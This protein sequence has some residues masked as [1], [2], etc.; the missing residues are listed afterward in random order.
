MKSRRLTFYLLRE[1]VEEFD[2]ALDQEKASTSVN[3]AASSGVDGRFHYL[4]PKPLIPAWVGFVQPL[5][6]GPLESIRS[7]STSGLLLLRASG[8]IFALTFGYGRSLLD[9]SKIEYQFGLRVALNRIDPRQIR[10]L[11]TKTFEDLVVST[12]TQASKSAEL[13]T[14]GVDVSKDILRAVTGEPRDPE[15]AK[16]IAGS[17]SLVMSVNAA[18]SDLP[19]LCNDLLSAFA[20]D[21]YKAEF[22]WI[23]QLSLVR[24]GKHIAALNDLLVAQLQSGETGSTHLAMPET[25]DWEDIDAFKIGGTRGH[26]YEDLDLDEYLH[27]LGDERLALT[28]E[29]L[30][31]RPVSIRFGRSGNFDKRWNLFQC[32]VTEQRL[33]EKLHV[34]IEG[35]WFAISDSL[36]GEVDQFVSGLPESS[37]SLISALPGEVEAD[38]NARLAESEPEHLLKLDAR[39]KRPGGATSG[40][41]FCDVLSDNGDLVHVK[42]KSR[43]STL[44]H[45]FAQG[46]VS[47]TTF[48]SDGHYRSEIRRLIEDEVPVD[49]RDTW[50]NLVPAAD[51]T[52]SRS[53]YRVTYAVIANSDRD[54]RDWLPFFSKLNLMQ[55]GRQLLNMGFGV[56]LAR[57][58][59]AEAT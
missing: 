54:G 31:S 33:E 57:V 34:L 3:L 58:P 43:S 49:T 41:E 27:R 20:A 44:S 23:D 26:I 2:D 11:D 39:I 35:R 1:E 9:L 15:F 36:V 22:G 52:V 32:I 6:D 7:S 42:R 55:Q 25:I 13:P 24:N 50:L 8:R 46:G 51:E 30:K 19:S 16:R 40:I 28:L 37:V 4:K 48:L 5:L 59:I 17:D 14:F 45:L 53:R 56:A 38:Y 10:S 21:D 29:N 47:A 12:S 18:P